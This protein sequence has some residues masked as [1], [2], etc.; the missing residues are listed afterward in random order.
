MND[1]ELG[2]LSD[3]QLAELVKNGMISDFS[4]KSNNDLFEDIGGSSLDLHLSNQAWEVDSTAKLSVNETVEQLIRNQNGQEIGLSETVLQKDHIYIVRLKEKVAL[5][6]FPRKYGLYGRASGRSSIGRLDV[7]TRL[8]VDRCPKYDEVPPAYHGDLFLEVV[9]LSF[10]IKVDEDVPLNQLRLFLGKPHLSELRSDEL[11]QTAPMLYLR[12]SEVPGS[13][14][15]LLRVDLQPAP[16]FQRA[17]IIAFRAKEYET[18]GKPVDITLGEKSHDANIYF[19]SVV[20]T[21]ENAVG[22]KMQKE[23]FYI[24]RSLERMFLPNDVSVTCL[25][26]SENL[27]EL[28][29]HYAGFAHPNFGRP[30]GD[31]MV[32][33]GAPLIFEARCHSFDVT[34]RKEEHFARIVYYKMSKPTDTPSSYSDQELQLSNYFRPWIEDVAN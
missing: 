33:L 19:E 6:R 18:I 7:L 30:P 9:P 2:V 32:S 17:K 34:I 20:E 16:N 10:D 1:W 22:L 8:I 23:R 27:G 5:H 15:D 31:A 4:G 11:V 14:N 28:R 21:K 3:E 13:N 24:F 26:Y 29:I 12:E 25:A